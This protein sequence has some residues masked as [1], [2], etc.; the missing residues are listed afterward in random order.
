MTTPRTGVTN[1]QDRGVPPEDERRE[2]VGAVEHY[3]CGLV[4]LLA[5]AVCVVLVY[6]ALVSA[7]RPLHL[8]SSVALVFIV[9]TAWVL[10]WLSFE[11]VWEWRAGRLTTQ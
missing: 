3:T 5:T 1:G 10:V 4:G 2:T 8:L 6:P 11:V 7:T 9:V